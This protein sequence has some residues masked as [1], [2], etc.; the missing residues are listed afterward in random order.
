MTF[1]RAAAAIALMLGLQV[2]IG[3]LWT[4]APG[5]IDLQLIPVV[6]FAIGGNQR[7]G[8]WVGCAAGLTQDAWFHAGLFGLNGFKKTLLGWTLGA[9]NARFDLQGNLAHFVAGVACSLGDS[10]LDP[11]LRRLIDREIAPV[12]WW[13]VGARALLAGLIVVVAFRIVERVRKSRLRERWS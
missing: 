6:L 12:A 7:T 10:V 9:L 3:R 8:M 2:G 1:L 4:A 13:Q 11:L 5:W